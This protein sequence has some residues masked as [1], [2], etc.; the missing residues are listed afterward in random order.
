MPATHRYTHDAGFGAHHAT[1]AGRELPAEMRDL[2]LPPGTEV[3]LADTD[4]DTG[5][6]ILAWADATGNGRHT[7]VDTEFFADHFEPLPAAPEGM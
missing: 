6:P 7:T 3:E 2:D 4:E 5:R 1:V